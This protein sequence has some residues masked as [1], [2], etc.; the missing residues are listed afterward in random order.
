MKY[1][2]LV[3]LF[4]FQ[5]TSF[6][7][8][9]PKNLAIVIG[10]S[11]YKNVGK[12][13]NPVND[14]I[15]IADKLKKLGFEVKLQKNADEN[16]FKKL[17]KDISRNSEKYNATLVYFA[18]HAV[19]LSGQNFLL[20][21]NQ[22]IPN[23][24]EDIKMSAILMDDLVNSIKSPFKI[25][26]MDACRDNPLIQTSMNTKARGLLSRGLANPSQS[27]GGLFIAYA[28][29]SGKVA[30]DGAGK[31]SPFAI[32]LAENLMNQESID[33]MFSK[34]TKQVLKLTNGTQRP[35]KYASLE[36]KYCLVG[37]CLEGTIVAK[38][39]P[40]PIHAEIKENN[41]EKIRIK[42][43]LVSKYADWVTYVYDT[44]Y[45]YQFSPHSF[46]YDPVKNTAKVQQRQTK[47]SKGLARLFSK[48]EN[49]SIN[50]VEF[51]CSKNTFKFTGYANFNKDGVM[52]YA[53]TFKSEEQKTL[54]IS[55]GSIAEWGI[56]SFCGAKT[57]SFNAIPSNTT[58]VGLVPAGTDNSGSFWWNQSGKIKYGE[59]YLYGVLY[60]L[61]KPI[62]EPK[63]GEVIVSN[64]I[65]G[66]AE[67]SNPNKAKILQKFFVDKNSKIVGISESPSEILLEPNSAGYNILKMD[68]AL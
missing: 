10:N 48:V 51:D 50:E 21:T 33:D 60:I 15:L 24:E 41:Y 25:I 68:C 16:N 6:A 34:V 45:I 12:L 18:G 35:F 47:T 39:Q 54:D 27:S 36:E 4:L 37:K 62:D 57:A 42:Q 65:I 66:T 56:M 38:V 8:D 28:T 20:S 67:C 46:E 49:Y 11:D 40:S 32:A 14:A 30:S 26:L 5:Q 44:D 23:T 58:S 31:N 2:V 43:D 29:E 19:Q 52:T 61:N 3:V 7:L 63:T 55:K 59:G 64:I 9:Q 53:H 13:E 1:I 17:I 22:E